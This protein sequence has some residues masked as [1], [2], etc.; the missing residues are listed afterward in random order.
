[1]KIKLLDANVTLLAGFGL[2]LLLMAAQMT[3]SISELYSL[4]DRMDKI[5]TD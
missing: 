1:M 5:V 4:R 3:L 2:V